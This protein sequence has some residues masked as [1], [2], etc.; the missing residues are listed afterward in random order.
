M[1]VTCCHM[2]SW[3]PILAAGGM[4]NRFCRLSRRPWPSPPPKSVQGFA[5]RQQFSTST[6]RLRGL[7]EGLVIP[8]NASLVKVRRATLDTFPPKVRDWVHTQLRD[9]KLT[10]QL[11]HNFYQTIP[12]GLDQRLKY[13]PQKLFTRRLSK[14]STVLEHT[15]DYHQSEIDRSFYNNQ[16]TGLH[17]LKMTV[18]LRFCRAPRMKE[19]F[20]PL[21][22]EDVYDIR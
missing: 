9:Q 3:I 2:L 4:W 20:K 7:A 17:R 11:T 6:G 13:L 14:L 21:D 15:S 8:F 12:L 16:Q 1:R 22:I 18:L 10:A 19:G 5:R